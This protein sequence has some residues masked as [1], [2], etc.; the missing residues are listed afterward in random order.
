MSPPFIVQQANE[1]SRLCQGSVGRAHAEKNEPD[2]EH[3]VDAEE[4]G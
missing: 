2:A 4:R 3:A 1:T